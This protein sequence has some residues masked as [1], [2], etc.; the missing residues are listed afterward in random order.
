MPN[1][2]TLAIEP[3]FTVQREVPGW[4]TYGYTLWGLGE[5]LCQANLPKRKANRCS[6]PNH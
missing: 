1:T 2:R 4:E 5:N 6:R 3:F